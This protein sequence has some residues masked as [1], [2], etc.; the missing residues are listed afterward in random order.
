MAARQS[1]VYIWISYLFAFVHLYGAISV[2]ISPALLYT[3]AIMGAMV[4]PALRM[5]TQPFVQTHIKENIKA[6]R[7]WH[8]RGEFTADQW[9]PS[10][11]GQ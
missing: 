7:F 3:D 1:R 9:I 6:P 5:F 2:N 4:S 10:T 11:K 8:V